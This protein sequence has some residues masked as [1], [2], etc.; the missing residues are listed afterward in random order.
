MLFYVHCHF[1]YGTSV[2]LFTL[3]RFSLHISCAGF[4]Q[5]CYLMQFLCLRLTR[6]VPLLW[7]IIKAAYMSPNVV[8][9][10]VAISPPNTLLL[11]VAAK[12]VVVCWFLTDLFLCIRT[13]C[14]NRVVCVLFLLCHC[15]LSTFVNFY[16]MCF[17]SVRL[18]L[19]MISDMWAKD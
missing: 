5:C 11:T 10:Y 4:G 2:F 14:C 7:V 6:F 12:E 15:A 9:C 13:L 18:S 16:L 17:F 8:K 3:H 19:I 1:S